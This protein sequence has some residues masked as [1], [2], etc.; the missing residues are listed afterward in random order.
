VANQWIPRALY[1]VGGVT[2]IGGAALTARGARDQREARKRQAAAEQQLEGRVAELKRHLDTTDGRLIAFKE[3]QLRCYTDAVL[4]MVEFLRRHDKQVREIDRLL[5][6]GIEVPFSPLPRP[7]DLDADVGT[8][9]SGA[10]A[11]VTAGTGTAATLAHAADR[12]GRASTGTPISDLHGAVKERALKALY[13]GGSLDR[14]GG[15]MVS[16]I[17]ARNVAVGGPAALAAGLVAKTAGSRALTHAMAYETTVAT[18]RA[19][20]DVVSERL[21][22]IEL[23]VAELSGVLNG[24]C[25]R[26]M[27][28]LDELESA[29][30]DADEHGPVL[31]KA[32]VLVVAVRDVASAPLLTDDH[33][34]T[35]ESG[36]LKVKYAPMIA[37]ERDE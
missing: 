10:A 5:V 15:G 20:L 8:W 36:T 4:R 13:G 22:G 12:Y 14:G 33:E 23:R 3:L 16:G 1:A 28:A 6:D 21:R 26:A 30:F 18:K 24:L 7:H 9:L 19:D 27:S 25:S 2:G 32:M 31:Q 29:P 11:A 35:V 34:L 37:E 17:R